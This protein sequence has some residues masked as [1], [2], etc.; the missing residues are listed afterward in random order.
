MR[1]RPVS[2][3]KQRKLAMLFIRRLIYRMRVRVWLQ[4]ERER[5]SRLRGDEYEAEPQ[6]ALNRLIGVKV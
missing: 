2:N 3:N 4:S 1:Y 5:I 6:R